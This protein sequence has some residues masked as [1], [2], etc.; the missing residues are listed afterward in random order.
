[1]LFVAQRGNQREMN[2]TPIMEATLG[3]FTIWLV[4]GESG[5]DKVCH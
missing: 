4:P 2:G 1:M 3:P 5:T